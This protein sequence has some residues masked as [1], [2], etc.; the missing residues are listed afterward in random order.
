[1]KALKK[2]FGGINLT[3]TKLIIFAIV[4]GVYTAFV[5]IVPELRDTSFHTIA[6]TFEVWVPIGIFIIMNSKS[7]MDS[8]LKCFVFFLISQPLVYLI[9]VP[10]SWQGWGLFKYYPY[11][12]AWTVFCLPMGYIGYFIKKDKWWG[13]LILAPMIA[14]MASEYYMYLGYFTFCRPYFI[15]ISIF[16]VVV[17]LLMPAVLFNN[18]KIVITGT[19]ISVVLAVFITVWVAMNPV[20]YETQVLFSVDEKDITEEYQVHLADD[21]YGDVSLKYFESLDAY[22]V[23]VD[24]KR[25]GN[26]ELIVKTPEGETVTYDLNIRLFSYDINQK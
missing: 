2:L 20:T 4:M 24:F 19:A 18:K 3:W 17:M 26:T 12:F 7:N 8:A 10:F 22:A 25:I 16:C 15:L 1:M 13:Y 11:W 23:N 6:V 9:Q 5:S 21:S 14:F